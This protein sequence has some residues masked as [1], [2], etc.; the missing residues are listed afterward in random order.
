MFLAFCLQ[1]KQIKAKYKKSEFLMKGRNIEYT[2]EKDGSPKNIYRKKF[3]RTS[4]KKNIEL[5]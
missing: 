1:I 5:L 3:R 2:K 4:E